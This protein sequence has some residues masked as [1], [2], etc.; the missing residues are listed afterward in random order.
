MCTHAYHDELPSVR[1]F[2]TWQTAYLAGAGVFVVHVLLVGYDGVIRMYLAEVL[3]HAGMSVTAAPDADRALGAADTAPPPAVL[4]SDVKLG[5][6]R[7]G[8]MLAAEARRRWP[9]VR[10][11][12]LSGT[13][14]N[15]DRCHLRAFDRF[16]LKPFT[17]DALLGAIIEATEVRRKFSSGVC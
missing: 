12:L 6:G 9:R 13:P 3:S 4:V 17:D 10:V 16:L 15:R 2:H 1:H 5:P 7:D 8:V 14:G 11:V